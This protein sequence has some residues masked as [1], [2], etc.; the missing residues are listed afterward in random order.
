MRLSYL[1]NGNH[2]TCTDKTWSLYWSGPQ[3][4]IGPA[5]TWSVSFQTTVKRSSP[6]RNIWVRSW[7]CGCLVTWFCYQLIAKPGNKTAAVL[8]P[9]PYRFLAA[10]K[11]LYEQSCLSVHHTFFTL[12]HHH[13]SFRSNYLWQKWWPCKRAWLEI[14]GQGNRGQNKFGPIWVFPARN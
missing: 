12:S 6:M 11:Q 8:W 4:L 1:Y 3:M 14:K 7:N 2:Y 13:E 10:T 5:M 9:D